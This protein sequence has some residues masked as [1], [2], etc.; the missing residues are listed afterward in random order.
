[1]FIFE[2]CNTKVFKIEQITFARQVFIFFELA[3]L[4]MLFILLFMSRLIT[5]TPLYLVFFYLIFFSSC[6][7]FRKVRKSQNIEEK[8]LAAYDYYD[9]K[10]HKKALV[11]LEDIFDLV[12]GTKYAEKVQYLYAYA[13]YHRKN[14][15]IASEYFE[16]FTRV[17]RNSVYTE[18]AAF[19]NAYCLYKQTPPYYLD[20]SNTKYLVEVIVELINAYP[21]SERLEEFIRLN[22]EMLDKLEHKAYDIVKLYMRLRYYP[23]AVIM[24]N[25]FHKNYPASKYHEQTAYV[26]LE[27]Q[28]LYSKSSLPSKQ[29]ERFKEAL[30]YYYHIIDRYPDGKYVKDAE[31]IF[32]NINK[33]LEKRQA[34]TISE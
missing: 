20:Q 2:F 14:Y 32:K 21:D 34:S 16:S 29:E 33:E 1:M 18:E 5:H 23:S 17:Y 11:L 13:N 7:P 27:A 25:N 24:V 31:Q 30:D 4:F 9:K 6:T 12:A 10:D 26:R 15:G 22:D 3:L 28:Y 19:M 8:V